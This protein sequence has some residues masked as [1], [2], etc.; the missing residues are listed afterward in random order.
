MIKN[1][2]LFK[3]FLGLIIL[4]FL[5]IQLVVHSVGQ[6]NSN[7]KKQDSNQNSNIEAQELVEKLLNF[8]NPKD[9]VISGEFLQAFLTAYQSF[10]EEKDISVEKKNIKNYLIKISKEPNYYKIIFIPKYAKGEVPNFGGTTSLGKGVIYRVDNK[11]F[12]IIKRYF[13]G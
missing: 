12:Q 3:S 7:T 5:S 1:E 6:S 11:T 9:M 10:Q 8:E 13:I 4:I 2:L